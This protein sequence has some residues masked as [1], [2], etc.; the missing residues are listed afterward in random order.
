MA[1]VNTLEEESFLCGED[2]DA[3]LDLIAHDCFEEDEELN[4]E[5]A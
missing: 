5:I 4:K 2:Y 1:S 3:I